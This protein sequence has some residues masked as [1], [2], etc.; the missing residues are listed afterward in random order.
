VRLFGAAPK[1]AGDEEIGLK[2][3]GAGPHVDEH[4]GGSGIELSLKL[5]W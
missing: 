1:R 2:D 3:V 4:G 5:D